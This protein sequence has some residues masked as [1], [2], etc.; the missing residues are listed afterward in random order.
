M[1]QE[2]AV[3]ERLKFFFKEK[4]LT[5]VQIAER[6][7]TTQQVV[8]RLL[9][10]KPFG[11]RTA[12]KWSKEFGLNP[13]WL[14]TGQGS[15]MLEEV[16]A[17]INTTKNVVELG[18]NVFAE[19]ILKMISEGVIYPASVVKDKDAMIK[20][21]DKEIQRLN[22]EVGALHQ[23]IEQLQNDLKGKSAAQTGAGVA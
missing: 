22:R 10:N 13:A 17:E 12:E 23:Q 14:I 9:N 3:G 4:G 18:A 16:N 20:D 11:K 21:K 6:V 19:Q 15:M 5:Q 1:S 8:Q 7:G 2:I